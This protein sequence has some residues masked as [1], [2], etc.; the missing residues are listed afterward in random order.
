MGAAS[1]ERGKR[2]RPSTLRGAWSILTNFASSTLPPPRSTRSSSPSKATSSR[3]ER[4]AVSVAS[5]TGNTPGTRTERIVSR[6]RPLRELSHGACCGRRQAPTTRPPSPT[7]ASSTRGGLA[8]A[9]G[10]MDRVPCPD[11]WAPRPISQPTNGT[12]ASSSSTGALQPVRSGGIGRLRAVRWRLRFHRRGGRS[13]AR[14]SHLRRKMRAAGPRRRGGPPDDR[15]NCASVAPTCLTPAA[16]IFTPSFGTEGGSGADKASPSVVL[17]SGS[18]H[19]GD[20]ASGLA[21]PSTT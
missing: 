17:A 21:S 1:A 12:T 16:V 5:S 15:A 2:S 10:G 18:P 9:V 19:T 11:R 13:V 3:G 14:R 7:T 8:G 6:P 4:R 20:W